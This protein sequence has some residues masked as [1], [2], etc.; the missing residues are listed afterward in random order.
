MAGRGRTA[1][2]PISVSVRQAVPAVITPYRRLDQT[3]A[4]A[5]AAARERQQHVAGVP[6]VEERRGVRRVGAGAA[7]GVPRDG[8]AYEQSQFLIGHG[9]TYVFHSL[10]PRGRSAW[11]PPPGP[12]GR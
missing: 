10:T 12:L 9:V 4:I 6:A 8:L 3:G 1:F 5:F 11:P 7:T 2:P